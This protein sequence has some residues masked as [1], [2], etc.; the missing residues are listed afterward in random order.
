MTKKAWLARSGKSGERDAWAID[1]GVTPG[2]FGEVADLSSCKSLAQ[3]RVMVDDAYPDDKPQMRANLAAQLWTLVGRMHNGDLVVLPLKTTHQLAIGEITGD[4]RYLADQQDIQRR[5]VRP[6]KWL[7]T[8][9][10]RTAVKQDLLYSLGAFLTYCEIS[11]HQA[12]AR[13]AAIAAAGIDPGAK[14]PLKTTKPKPLDDDD[15]AVDAGQ[16]DL[17]LFARDRITGLIQERFA[18]HDMEGLVEAILVAQ[19]FTCRTSPGGTDGG[20]DILAGSGPL[21]MDAPKL[22]VQVKSEQTPVGEPVVTQLLGSVSKH[23]SAQGLLV[24]WGGVTNPAR[25]ALLDNYFRLRMWD[26]ADLIDMI[27]V[28]YPKLPEE[29]RASLPLK[30]IWIAV[31][32]SP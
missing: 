12:A 31:E 2:G 4:Y 15:D 18:G 28:H 3:V 5:H 22:V 14:A 32:E 21:G 19:G 30:Q 1:T 25:K 8:D 13:I 6:V 9:V 7:R 24:A 10:P 17:E 11:R 23:G 29:I 26:A 20:V 16:V 27:T